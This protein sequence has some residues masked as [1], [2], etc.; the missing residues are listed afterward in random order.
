MPSWRSPIYV[1]LLIWAPSKKY[2]VKS[3]DFSSYGGTFELGNPES[4][5]QLEV[6]FFLNSSFIL[7]NWAPFS[8]SSESK[9]VTFSVS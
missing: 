3:G 2:W 7:L 6:L 1:I 4:L 5:D 9:P 8:R